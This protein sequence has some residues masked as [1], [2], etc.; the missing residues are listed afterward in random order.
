MFH[1][2]TVGLANVLAAIEKYSRGYHGEAWKP[3][4][5]LQRLAAEGR[6][7]NG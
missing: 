7:F 4:S 5:L 2:E 1:A 6:G 3:A